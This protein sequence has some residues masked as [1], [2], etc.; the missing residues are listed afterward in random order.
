MRQVEAIIFDVFGTLVDWRTGVA[1][2]ARPVFLAK[3]IDIDPL[4]FAD[5][6]RGEYQPSMERIRSGNRDYVPLDILHLENLEI[7]LEK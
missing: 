2:A 5:S 3:D 6:W 1:D 4:A 7:T